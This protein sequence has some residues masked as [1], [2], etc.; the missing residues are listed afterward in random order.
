MV[1]LIFLSS[2]PVETFAIEDRSKTYLIGRGNQ[3]DIVID[4]E[5]VSR[6]HAKI[7]FVGSRWQIEDCGSR[8]R[9]QINQVPSKSEA[10]VNGDLVRIGDAVLLFSEVTHSR[11]K[12]QSRSHD[13]TTVS[14]VDMQAVFHTSAGET[15]ESFAEKD[16]MQTGLL[17]K[18]ATMLHIVNTPEQLHKLTISSI[19][20]GIDAGRIH[21]WIRDQKGR[22]RLGSQFPS[23]KKRVEPSLTASL[24]LQNKQGILFGGEDQQTPV[25]KRSCGDIV[26]ALIPGESSPQG[27]IECCESKSENFSFHDLEYLIALC[28]IVGPALHRI[29]QLN[30]LQSSTAELI[31]RRNSGMMIGESDCMNQLQERIQQ[32]ALADSTILITGE[33]GTGKELVAGLIHGLSRRNQG[34]LVTVNCAAFT[35]TLLE[36]ELFGHEAG[37]FTGADRKRIGAFERANGGTLFLDE[38]GEMSQECQAKVLRAMEHYPFERVGGSEPVSI[39]VRIVAATHRDLH[40]RVN[41]E[42]FRAD[43]VYRLQVIELQMPPLRERGNDILKLAEHFLSYYCQKQGK[44]TPSIAQSALNSLL[45]YHWP[46]NVRELRNMMERVVVFNQGEEVTSRDFIF[47][48]DLEQDFPMSQFRPI[49]EMESRYINHVMNSVS[50]NKTEACR[51]LG[52]SRATLYNKLSNV[53]DRESVFVEKKAK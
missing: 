43:L 26:C 9:I 17:G 36:S 32:V 21:I 29:K 27:V 37:A 50:G 25:A 30:S 20:K 7:F 35:E 33:T 53:H 6:V 45:E 23:T 44:P 41:A 34:P 14:Q 39:D 12:Q 10:L 22:L 13:T 19:K 28:G 48:S 4:D 5:L 15:V 8:N 24:S 38:I 11:S 49:H 46:G 52:I 18:L 16:H 3:C 42:K 51:I 31:H 40:E 2:I 1:Q 47:R